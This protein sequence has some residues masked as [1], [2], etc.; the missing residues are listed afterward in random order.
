[1]AQAVM[2]NL[3]E[4][5]IKCKLSILEGATFA[6]R[7]SSGNYEM[8]L[9][10][11]AQAGDIGVWLMRVIYSDIHG[12]G[13]INPKVKELILEQARIV[14]TLKRTELLREIEEIIN[15]DCAPFVMI[16]QFDSIYFQ[17]KG[18]KG[19]KYLSDKAPDFRYAH[20]E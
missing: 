11:D 13:N 5:G 1:V 12:F 17:Q 20:Y 16:C 3:Q 6:E 8:F 2:D 7:R 14:D 4:I 10:Q 15:T 9:N 19:A 18:L